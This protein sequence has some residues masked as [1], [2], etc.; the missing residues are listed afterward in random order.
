MKW[1]KQDQISVMSSLGLIPSI[2][3]LDLGGNNLHCDCSLLDLKSL[4]FRLNSTSSVMCHSPNDLKARSLTLIPDS[5]LTCDYAI[6]DG[7]LDDD[8]YDY[9]ENHRDNLTPV[10]NQ[11]LSLRPNVRSLPQSQRIFLI[12]ACVLTAL[13][14]GLSV[15]LAVHCRRRLKG[16]LPVASPF[17]GSARNSGLVAARNGICFPVSSSYISNG[18]VTDLS[19]S[20]MTTSVTTHSSTLSPTDCWYYEEESPS[21]TYSK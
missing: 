19:D 8:Y 3:S 15:F 5:D 16:C 18:C 17:R 21:G 20:L 10:S 2:S 4:L 12:V 14:T 6:H 13:L 1:S 9:P 7:A 11:T